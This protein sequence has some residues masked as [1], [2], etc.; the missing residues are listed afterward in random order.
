ELNQPLAALRTLSGNTVRFLQ[1]GA[2]D[3]ASSN[4]HTINELVD[5]MGKITASLRA[6]ARRSDDGGEAR[7]DQAVDAALMLLHPRLQRTNV[8][9]DRD[10]AQEPGD[11]CLAIDQTRLEQ[12]LVNLIGNALDAMRDQVDRRLWLT[13]ADTG[14]HFQLDVRDN[15]PGIAPDAR[16]H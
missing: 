14:S 15:G 13:G 11:V 9:I 8:R 16:V 1:R 12:I 5:R 3:I 10:Y 7:L 2:L 4:L 6:F